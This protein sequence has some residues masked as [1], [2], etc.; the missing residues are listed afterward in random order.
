[1]R[2]DITEE[3]P[4]TDETEVDEAIRA[5]RNHYNGD[6]WRDALLRELVK[7]ILGY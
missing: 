6:A 5:V 2:F 1:M 4:I 7:V 3:Q